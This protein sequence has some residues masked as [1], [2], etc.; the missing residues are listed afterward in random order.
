MIQ[1]IK[2][3]KKSKLCRSKALLCS[4]E[5]EE[6]HS[7][8]ENSRFLASVNEEEEELQGFSR[9]NEV[10]VHPTGICPKIKTK[11]RRT[12]AFV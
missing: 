4:K 3:L 12:L 5:E 1:T 8:E 10:S 7:K 9:S 2:K 11:S 6:L